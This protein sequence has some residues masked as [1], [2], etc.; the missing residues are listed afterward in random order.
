M[1]RLPAAAVSQPV[2]RC[3]GASRRRR[4]RLPVRRSGAPAEAAAAAAREA[5]GRRSHHGR[6]VRQTGGAANGPPATATTPMRLRWRHRAQPCIPRP[7]RESTSGSGTGS[8]RILRRRWWCR[9]RCGVCRT[10]GRCLL[11]NEWRVLVRPGSR[12]A[13][14]WSTWPKFVWRGFF[15]HRL[16]RPGLV[17]R[18]FHLRFPDIITFCFLWIGGPHES[19]AGKIALRL[20]S[21]PNLF[22]GFECFC[23]PAKLLSGLPFLESSSHVHSLDGC[24]LRSIL[25]V[26]HG[27]D[28]PQSTSWLEFGLWNRR[29]F[30]VSV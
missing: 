30:P 18:N 14:E 26:E 29:G 22:R 10:P 11:L 6:G 28:S 5:A 2:R 4:R 21:S 1:R 27:C 12:R 25:M 9:R 19:F 24:S 13:Y 16:W 3:R 20:L 8:G 23:P 17:R 15:W 7:P